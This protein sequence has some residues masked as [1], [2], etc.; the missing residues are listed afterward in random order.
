MDMFTK[1]GIPS[2][3]LGQ[4]FSILKLCEG[5]VNHFCV[6]FAFLIRQVL[7][8]RILDLAD[9]DVVLQAMLLLFGCDSGLWSLLSSSDPWKSI[10][11]PDIDWGSDYL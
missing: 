10:R 5:S 2:A 8:I 6:A 7:S 11:L 9:I 3:P 4:N 1:W